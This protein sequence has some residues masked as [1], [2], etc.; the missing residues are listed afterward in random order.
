MNR[1]GFVLTAVVL[2]SGCDE[3]SAPSGGP[4]PSAAAAPSVASVAPAPASAA[5]SAASASKKLPAAIASSHKIRVGSDLSYPPIESYKEGTK[6]AQGLD[7]DVCAALAKK[8]AEDVTCDFQNGDFDKLLADL[9]AGKYDVVMSSVTDDKDREAKADFVDYFSAGMSVLV[10]KG[11]P[12]KLKSL[13]DLCGKSLGAQKGTTEEAFA[14]KQKAACAKAGKPAL[15]IVTVTADAESLAQLKAGKL[16]ADLEDF[17]AAAYVA[18]TSG[19]GNDYELFGSPT[20]PTPYGIAVAKSNADLRDALAGA[21]K[22][23][24]AD[25]TYDKVLEKWNLKEGA[26]RTAAIN[27]G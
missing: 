11:N 8:I 16:A 17:P 12:L 26:L 6:E 1:I 15:T 7:V 10:K 3:K 14:N 18:K 22:A 4:A 23:I 13:D 5:P 2:A 20:D 21:L 9:G 25:G 19:G 24:L 27:G